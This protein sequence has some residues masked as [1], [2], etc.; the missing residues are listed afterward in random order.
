M[1]E[2]KD[3]LEQRCPRLGSVVSFR[4]CRTS[5][6]DVSACW[7]VFDCWW[8]SFDVVGYFK[9]HLSEDKFNILVNTE[10]KPKTVSLVELIEQAKKRAS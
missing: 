6:D 1:D 9:K 5:G 8:E 4:Y 2:S 3:H 10:P 7:K